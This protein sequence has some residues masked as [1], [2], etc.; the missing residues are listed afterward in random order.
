MRGTACMLPSST[1]ETS[2]RVSRFGCRDRK[3]FADSRS[4][5][6][7]QVTMRRMSYRTGTAGESRLAAESAAGCSARTKT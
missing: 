6:S 3:H 5:R 2:T 7:L 4:G 1:L